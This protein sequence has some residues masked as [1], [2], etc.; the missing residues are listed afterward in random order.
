MLSSISDIID[1][2]GELSRDLQATGEGVADEFW[3]EN[4]MYRKDKEYK[5]RGTHL[6]SVTRRGKWLRLSWM[7]SRF[8]KSKGKWLVFSERLPVARNG[9]RQRA[10]TLR[11][12]TAWE[13]ESFRKS[14]DILSVLREAEE[15]LKKIDR[16][17][18]KYMR[19]MS[20]IA[21]AED[22]KSAEEAIESSYEEWKSAK[23]VHYS[24]LL[25]KSSDSVDGGN[26]GS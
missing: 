24:D 1:V 15:E 9:Y 14:E 12:P 18:A 17:T 21:S 3:E 23:S 13:R 11:K 25:E 20:K 10:S 5:N 7:K 19:I 4:Q 2:L 26:N 16:A 22:I 8:V 6:L